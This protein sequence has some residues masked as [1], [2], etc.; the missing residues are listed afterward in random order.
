MKNG[1]LRIALV[2]T[3]LLA[4]VV[5]GVQLVFFYDAQTGFTADGG[6]MSGVLLGFLV[7]GVFLPYVCT[8]D[9]TVVFPVRRQPLAGLGALVGG[10]GLLAGAAMALLQGLPSA[11]VLAF[12]A[13]TRGAYVLYLLFS[14]LAGVSLLYGAVCHFAGRPLF[15]GARWLCLFPVLAVTCKA[16]YLFAVYTPEDGTF[17]NF[18]NLT[19][20]GLQLGFFTHLGRTCMDDREGV[21]RRALLLYAGGAAAAG[22]AS[23][24]PNLLCWGLGLPCVQSADM[25]HLLSVACA[26]L[27]ALTLALG[28]SLRPRVRRFR[29]S[30]LQ[31]EEKVDNFAQELGQN[32]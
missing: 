22:L 7:L 14:A 11:A 15:E 28:A 10:L 27:Y 5:R 17:V 21:S 26:A 3:A 9:K 18:L 32:R 20:L 31:K 25:T 8:E 30:G 29:R 1:A 2:L 13:L 6:W 16:L 19:A 23:S 4:T 24:V 12:S